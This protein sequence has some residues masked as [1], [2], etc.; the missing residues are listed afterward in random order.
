[1][2]DTTNDAHLWLFL[3]WMFCFVFETGFCV[4]QANL[5]LTLQ[6]QMILNP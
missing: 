2:N 6:S 1:M 3:F 4:S 5:E